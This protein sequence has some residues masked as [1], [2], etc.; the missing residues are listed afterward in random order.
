MR[1]ILAAGA[2][3]LGLSFAAGQ[4]LAAD[5]L[6]KNIAMDGTYQVDLTNPSGSTFSV[7][8]S[9]QT[10][11]TVDDELI[12]FL[13]IDMYHFDTLGAKDP[14]QAYR[15][16][17]LTTDFGGH[18][19]SDDQK[20]QLG[21][22]YL[23]VQQTNNPFQW[24]ALQSAAWLV[25][26]ASINFRGNTALQTASYDLVADTHRVNAANVKSFLSLDGHQ[27]GVTVVPEP[28][29]WA[30]MIIGF[31]GVGALM[32]RRSSTFAFT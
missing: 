21:W 1:T 32:R 14:P 27:S 25:E 11:T 8:D 18:S 23:Q 4:A 2:L 28:A 5:I 29:T 20:G 22:F 16:S 19:L 13:C 30:L 12:R 10:L 3:A 15:I 24:A 31:G 9:I 26:G 7:Y 6:V 17:E